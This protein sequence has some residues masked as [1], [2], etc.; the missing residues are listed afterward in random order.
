M[1]SKN[2]KL[3]KGEK[4]VG[5]TDDLIFMLVKISNVKLDENATYNPNVMDTQMFED[6]QKNMK[7]Y[8]YLAPCVVI[9]DEDL[10]YFII[11]GAHRIEGLKSMGFKMALVLLAKNVS[12]AAAFAGA[13]SFNKLRGDLSGRKMTKMLMQGINLYGID[14]MKKFT[15]L[16]A[17]KM[18]EYVGAALQAEAEFPDKS[19]LIEMQKVDAIVVRELRDIKAMPIEDMK[20]TMVL[21]FTQSDFD[22]IVS[23]VLQKLDKNESKA[24][25]K[26]CNFYGA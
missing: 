8:G 16:D 20:R 18:E 24:V 9:L 5:E 15:S 4:I 10:K 11:D 21:S 26:L 25:L 2:I 17:G 13:I 1:D 6:L 7:V 3:E 22:D 19:E 12:K 23:P 14:T